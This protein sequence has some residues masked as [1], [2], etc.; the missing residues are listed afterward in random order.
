MQEGLIWHCVGWR[1]LCPPEVKDTPEAPRQAKLK[2]REM[3]PLSRCLG[4]HRT[5]L[6]PPAC[7]LPLDPTPT[8]QNLLCMHAVWR[9][10]HPLQMEVALTA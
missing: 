2:L 3:G 8:W 6:G 4:L 7:F 5:S 10:R 1:S 9:G